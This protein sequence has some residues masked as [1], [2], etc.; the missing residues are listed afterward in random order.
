[1]SFNEKIFLSYLKKL[2][3]FENKPTI[4]VGV[5]GGPDSMLLTYLLSKWIN[6]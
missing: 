2:N 4:A 1:M 3:C 5:S 6:S